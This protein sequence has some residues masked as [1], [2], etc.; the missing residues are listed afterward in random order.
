MQENFAK[1]L[2]R[3]LITTL[4]IIVGAIV[5]LIPAIWNGFPHVYSDTGAYLA[6]AFEGKIPLGRPTG[7]GMFIR[8]TAIGNSLWSTI[9]IQA[10]LF[11]GLLWRALKIA[12][13]MAKTW[14]VFPIVI[15]V[16][17]V[18]TGANWYTGQ[19]MP[20]VFTGLVILT[21]YLLLFDQALNSFAKI[22]LSFLAYVFCFSHYSHMALLLA[23]SMVFLVWNVWLLIR[24][25]APSFSI[26]SLAWTVTP[27]LLAILSF[28]YVNYSND[29]GWRMTRSSHV[30]TM[31]KL[32]ES[33]MLKEYLDET[34][35]EMNWALCPYADELPKSA[36]AFI[37]NGDSPFKKTGYWDNSRPQYDSLIAD[38]FSRPK[39]LGWY[40]KDGAVSTFE[41][42]FELSVAEGLTPYNENSSPYKFFERAMPDKI[43]AYLGTVQFDRLLSF[44]KEKLILQAVMIIS[45]L[46]LLFGLFWGRKRL[47][48]QLLTLS[49]IAL[50]AYVMNAAITGALANVYSRLQARIA[51]LIPFAAVLLAWAIISEMRKGKL[52]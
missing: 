12:L 20:D 34:C 44:D 31:A 4:M 40:V 23:M 15:L 45:A 47:N 14:Q 28:Y 41:Q 32:S 46:I 6:T 16:A 42:L 51:W 36:A 27:A 49:V 38:F 29:L 43:P 2:N 5:L 39:Y 48:S 30:F 9:F 21:F 1:T 26:F 3:A 18:T 24:K 50:F 11:S 19:L 25:K 8:Y 33:G 13:P 7:Y 10:L 17:G 52:L 22:G 35:E 37:W